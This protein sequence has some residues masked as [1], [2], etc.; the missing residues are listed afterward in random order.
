M[1]PK[2]LSLAFA[3]VLSLSMSLAAAAKDDGLTGSIEAFRVIVTEDGQENF[4]PADKARPT[5]VIE[6]RLTYRNDGLDPVRSIFI[7]DPIPSG[8]AYIEASASRPDQGRVEFS[9]DG[10]KS[11][12]GWPIEIIEKTLDGREKTTR[13]T[14]EMVT[15]IRW[16]VTEMFTPE[17]E[18]TVSYRTLI[19]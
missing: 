17:H 10:G 15:H 16:T 14:P 5:D 13:A 8:T 9:I 18:V 6:Y 7:T 11:Y 2:R 4:L 1:V 12:H 3:L 19:K